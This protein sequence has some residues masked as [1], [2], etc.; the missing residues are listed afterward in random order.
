MGSLIMSLFQHQ[1]AMGLMT[2]HTAIYDSFASNVTTSSGAKP[3]AHPPL[4]YLILPP[5]SMSPP[6]RGSGTGS[7]QLQMAFEGFC[8]TAAKNWSRGGGGGLRGGL[9][10]L[11][12]NGT[13]KHLVQRCLKT[14]CIT[15][16][17][18]C[19][20]SS[21]QMHPLGMEPGTFCSEMWYL[22][23]S[24][25]IRIC[26]PSVKL[27]KLNFNLFKFS[28]GPR[29]CTQQCL[30]VHQGFL[31]FSL[32]NPMW[33]RV[34]NFLSHSFT[35]NNDADNAHKAIWVP[36]HKHWPHNLLTR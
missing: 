28:L 36:K 31:K 18:S 30:L 6:L 27:H 3:R 11:V 9:T 13:P 20:Y 17:H 29:V 25:I 23:N 2:S 21:S 33:P 15:A 32:M 35:S 24:S 34:L 14:S 26:C 1:M 5:R 22:S 8:S 12:V 4:P 19:F 10:L 7:S 16:C